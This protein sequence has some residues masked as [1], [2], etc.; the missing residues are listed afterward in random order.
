LYYNDSFKHIDTSTDARGHYSMVFESGQITYDGNTNVVGVIFYTG[1]SEYENDQ[2]QAVPSGT[3]DIVKNLRLS[4]VVR[5]NAGQSMV[6]SIRADSSLA[7]DGEDHLRMTSVWEKFY[8][9]VADAGTLR[10]T[11]RPLSSGIVPQIAVFCIYVADN[12]ESD[13]VNAPPGIAAR[14]VRANSMFQIR[15]AIPSQMAPQQYDVATSLE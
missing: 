15:L 10:I 13:Y 11:A 12:C 9:R 4:R 8:V 2:V 3:A 1:G 5:I 14:R 6:T 7:Y